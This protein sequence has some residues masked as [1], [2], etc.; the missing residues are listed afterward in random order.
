MAE[1]RVQ[2]ED[3]VEVMPGVFAIL[4]KPKAGGAAGQPQ[5]PQQQPQQQPS[6]QQPQNTNEA[7]AAQSQP[8]P[9]QQGA[10]ASL[11]ANKALEKE[12]LLSEISALTVSLGHLYRSNEELKEYGDDADCLEAITENIGVITRRTE[13]LHNLVAHLLAEFEITPPEATRDMLD[14]S[15]R[16]LSNGFKDENDGAGN[17]GSS[18]GNDET[19]GNGLW[20]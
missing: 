13:T 16:K 10:A 6:Q 1:E 5:Q 2:W 12:T 7:S 11:S 18:G 19:G 4:R 8:L 3:E 15:R 9:Q 20:M 14:F 17:G